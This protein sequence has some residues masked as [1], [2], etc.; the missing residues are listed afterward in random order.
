MCVKLV[1]GLTALSFYA[2]RVPKCVIG[3]NTRRTIDNK[4]VSDDDD[5][6]AR[7]KNCAMRVAV[8]QL[9]RAWRKIGG[10]NGQGDSVLA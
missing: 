3:R 10:A 5:Q 8:A 2:I 1:Y 4:G 7:R 9:K 6:T